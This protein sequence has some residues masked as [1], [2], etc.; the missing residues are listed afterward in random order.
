MAR[1]IVPHEHIG[2][3]LVICDLLKPENIN[4]TTKPIGL[5]VS[6][7]LAAKWSRDQ[8]VICN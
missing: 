5:S 2:V 1:V 8:K 4:Q 6:S 7:R 3:A